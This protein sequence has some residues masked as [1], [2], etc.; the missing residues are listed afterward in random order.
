MIRTAHLSDP[1]VTEGPRFRDC[2][3]SFDFV[4]DD[5]TS[6]GVQLWLVD[7]D[8]SGQ[9]TLHESTIAERNA[10]DERFQRMAE[11]APVCIVCGNHD[12]AQ[13][14]TG[15]ERLTGA[16]PIRVF[17]DL[18]A[19][20]VHVQGGEVCIVHAPYQWKSLLDTR[21]SADATAQNITASAALEAAIE[22]IVS[23]TPPL[24]PRIL[25][26]HLN[27]RGATTSGDE[28]MANQEVEVTR[29][30]LQRL[31]IDYGAFGHIHLHQ[32]LT[33]KACY[34]GN[35]FAQSHG[36]TD[37]KGYVIA[38]VER[39]Q[40]PVINRRLTPSRPM[41]TVKFKWDGTAFVPAELVE[42]PDDAEVRIKVD[43]PEEYVNTAPLQQLRE[44][45]TAIGAHH[46]K[47]DPRTV[48]RERLRS[49]AMA[50]ARTNEQK[51][52]AYW[53]SLGDAAPPAEQ[54]E[55]CLARLP[56]LDGLEQLSLEK[57]RAA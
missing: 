40:L 18:G 10:L 3:E 26:A 6:Q 24:V 29:E 2:L 35:H 52:R 28:I 44:Q 48:P 32:M 17:N 22:S 12:V 46:V 15:Y 20:H 7:G 41:V 27:V 5:A 21:A 43:V 54:Q 13:D 9:E 14:L 50:S 33:T 11:V 47:L 36:E 25:A 16:W 57:D 51:L 19:T 42:I 53:E 4:I 8:L 30:W 31:D 23:I 38:D 45:F 1:H 37:R 56:Q 34:S 49:E 39:G 55:R